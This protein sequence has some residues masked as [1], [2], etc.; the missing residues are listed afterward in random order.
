MAVPHIVRPPMQSMYQTPHP[1]SP[2]SV[3]VQD[4]SARTFH[5]APHQNLY[6]NPGYTFN[7]HP[8]FS[9]PDTSHQ[10]PSLASQLPVTYSHI[11]ALQSFSLH[12]P[13]IER[14]RSLPQTPTASSNHPLSYPQPDGARAGVGVP[15][16]H[17]S[18][19]G[20]SSSAPGPIP[21]TTPLVVSQGPDG[22]Q[23][24]IFEYSRDRI[25]VPYT[26]KCNVESVNQATLSRE[27]KEANCV[28]PKACNF[29]EVKYNGTRFEY[30]TFCNELGWALAALN[31][32]LR[33]KRGLIQR[34]VDSWR[35]SASDVKLR[36]R[37]VRR[38]EKSHK[39]QSIPSA[40]SNARHRPFDISSIGSV[41]REPVNPHTAQLQHGHFLS[42]TGSEESNSSSV[43]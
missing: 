42:H 21:A 15:S 38:L 35:N 10:Q 39:R 12:D 37:R 29:R 30:E 27:F 32:E 26:I 5:N 2:S 18:I 36:S 13:S 17:G 1:A 33:G 19:G 22:V 28:Y 4:H 6:F 3:H 14:P 34:A 31:P 43:S 41:S 20:A 23:S 40:S 25:K 7:T 24:I 16:R 9:L 8:A 11:P